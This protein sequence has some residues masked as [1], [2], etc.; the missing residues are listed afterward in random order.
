MSGHIRRRGERS[1]EL[2]YDIGR[3]SSTGERQVRYVSFKGTKREAEAELTRLLNGLNQ[4]TYVEPT[5]MSVGQ[6]LEHW[7]KVNRDWAAKTARRHAG[8]VRHQI[9]PRLGAIP[10]RKLTSTAIEPCW[11]LPGGD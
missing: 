1:W 5:K 2:K 3:D 8:I 11:G 4:G 10:L 9:N 7:L 6:Y